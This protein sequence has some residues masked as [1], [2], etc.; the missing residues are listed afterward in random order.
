M[1]YLYITLSLSLV[2]LVALLGN[3]IS[4]LQTGRKVVSV[5]FN[6]TDK[7]LG[8]FSGFIN[9]FSHLLTA[10][11]WHNIGHN[12]LTTVE[13]IFVRS[14]INL[15]KWWK[16]FMKVVCRT[17][18]PTNRGSVSFFLKHIEEHKEAQRNIDNLDQKVAGMLDK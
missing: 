3:K 14:I 1:I 10:G 15:N 9:K 12:I 16:K 13:G 11:S 6:K 8:S 5:T 17:D 2:G 7:W 4:E 18:I